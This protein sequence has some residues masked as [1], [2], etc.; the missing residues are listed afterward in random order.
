MED[1]KRLEG[2]IDFSV[3]E[4]GICLGAI[5]KGKAYRSIIIDVKEA[6]NASKSNHITVGSA[7]D[8]EADTQV[9]CF[10]S[11]MV[12]NYEEMPAFK[13]DTDIFIEYLQEGEAATKGKAHVS[14]EYTT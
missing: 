6:F 5:P 4:E 8:K 11:Q 12:L 7:V 3:S 2:T 13:E 10:I 14:I 9:D 1:I